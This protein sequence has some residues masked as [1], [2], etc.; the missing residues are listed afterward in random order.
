MK[1]YTKRGDQGETSLADG[2]AA[3][4][5]HAR[6]MAYGAMDETNAAI[7]VAIASCQDEQIADML[8]QIQSYMLETGAELANPKTDPANGRITEAHVTTLEKWIDLA[9]DAVE[10]LKNFI[11]PGGTETAARLHMARTVC[12]RAERELITFH[13]TAGVSP[14]TLKFVN[15]LADLLFA[16]A[17]LA[18][19]RAG[20]SDVKWTPSS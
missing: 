1:L 9:S 18:N 19:H 11:L 6:V 12:R 7:G 4:K 17:R 2:S 5:N 15:R 16:L 10:E 20:R 13:Q 3:P 8:T 14:H